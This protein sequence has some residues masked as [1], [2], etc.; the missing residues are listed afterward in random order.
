M[1]SRFTL[2]CRYTAKMR[3]K[4]PTFRLLQF[5]PTWQGYILELTNAC[6]YLEIFD[7]L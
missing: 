5:E 7:L 6:C 2:S 4:T 1:L 3:M